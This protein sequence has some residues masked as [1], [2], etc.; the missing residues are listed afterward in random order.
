MLRGDNVNDEEGHRAVFSE[1]GVPAS[2][3]APAK[4]LDIISKLLGM[5]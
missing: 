1:Q 4:F 3:M 5:T 2:Q